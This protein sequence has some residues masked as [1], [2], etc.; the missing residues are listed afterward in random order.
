MLLRTHI[1]ITILAV[2]LFLSS[3]EHKIFLVFFALLGTALPDVDSKFSFLGRKLPSRIIQIFT[4][5]RGILHSFTFLMIITLVL[6]FIFPIAAFP[7]FLGYSLHLFLD[8]FTIE[9]IFPFYP[10]KKNVCG[11]I[12]TGKIVDT[13]MFIFFGIVDLLILFL[14]VYSFFY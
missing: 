7:L 3:F 5:H 6:I 10:W 2:L 11:S 9:G 13:S 12:K 14:V 4:K 8:S 1:A